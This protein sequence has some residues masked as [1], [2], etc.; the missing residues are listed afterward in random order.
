M[1]TNFETLKKSIYDL[2][3]NS[4]SLES[5]ILKLLDPISQYISDNNFAQNIDQ[6]ITI[7]TLDRDDNHIFTIND[8]KLLS[9][10]FKS[11]TSLINCILLL[12]GGLPN[13]KLKYNNTVTEEIIFK[14]IAYIFLVI[15]PKKTN[16]NW[17]IE[18]KLQIV[19]FVLSIYNIIITSGIL[20]QL[21]EKIK[22]YFK[23]KGWCKCVCGEIDKQQVIETQ[24][25]IVSAELQTHV[26][27]TKNMSKLFIS[28]ESLHEKID[29]LNN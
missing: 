11:I 8:I 29:M 21:I 14:L 16:K 6:I 27:R 12:I 4:E 28:I 17:S 1:T 25:P 20:Q 9:S 2:I 7:I 10:D 5:D 13:L 18:D 26:L 23:K 15:V 24:M 19:D 3:E 22:E